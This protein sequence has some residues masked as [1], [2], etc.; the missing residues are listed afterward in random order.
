MSGDRPQ[1]T[2]LERL[3]LKIWRDRQKGFPAFV[4]RMNPDALDYATGAWDR[5]LWEA[6]HAE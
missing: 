6:A 3:A 2:D 5:C 1:T 4:R